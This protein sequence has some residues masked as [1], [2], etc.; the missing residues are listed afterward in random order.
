MAES[1][2]ALND[3]EKILWQGRPEASVLGVWFFTK[4]IG[5]AL[6]ASFLTFWSLGVFGGIWAAATNEG[7]GFNPLSSI[8][9]ALRIVVPLCALAAFAYVVALRK[10]Y[11]Y[12]VT[13]QRLV[14]I[15][16]LL[17]KKRRSVH[18]HKVTDVEVSQNFLE[19]LLGIRSLKIFTAG[20]SSMGGWGWERA[21]ITFAGLKEADTAEQI[22]NSTLK[23]YRATGE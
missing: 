23:S 10:T 21:E 22:V 19:Q 3:G 13:N 5:T 14:F 7:Q 16:G 1:N 8:G 11:Q 2:I 20:T 12:F 17:M 9:Q 15:G 4:V 18:Y 6:I